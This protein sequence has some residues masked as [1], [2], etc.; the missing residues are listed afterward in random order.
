MKIVM[1]EPL[2]ITE[3]Q[4]KE[5]LAKKA[6]FDYEFVF[7]GAMLT[8]QEKMLRAQDADVLVVANSPL[9]PEVIENAPRLK[10]ISVGFTGVDHIPLN[11]CRQKN[12]LVCNAQG[13]CTRSVAELTFGLIFDCLRNILPCDSLTREGKT[14]AGFIGNELYGKTLGIV[15]AGEIGT[16]V[17]NIAKA[18]GCRVL[19]YSRSRREAA[20]RAGV[21][22]VDLDTLMKESDIIT[23]HVP[24]TAE[25]KHMISAEKIALMKQSAILINVARGSVVDSEALA[26]ALNAGKIR[27]AGIDVFENEPPIQADHPLLHSKNTILTPHVAFATQESMIN[28][29]EIVCDNI[30]AWAHGNPMNVK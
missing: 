14:K 19:G 7:C 3:A 18:F 2:G 28:R 24:A 13:Y 11:L 27:G 4:A 8:E 12:I 17:A 16:Y 29:A 5:I 20:I 9:S 15:G 25:T 6:D 10:M 22:H 26:A 23:L 1:L 30:C 21:E